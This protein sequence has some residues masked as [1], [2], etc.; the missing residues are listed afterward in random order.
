ML[1]TLRD[2]V[3]DEHERTRVWVES[4]TGGPFDPDSFDL[5]VANKALEAS[6]FRRRRG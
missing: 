3:D 1:L 2:A 6:R 4:M 5:A